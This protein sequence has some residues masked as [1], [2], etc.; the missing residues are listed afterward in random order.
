MAPGL[1]VNWQ[2]RQ[3]V[4]DK[5]I[6]IDTAGAL[7]GR[8]NNAKVCL[9]SNKTSR[10]HAHLAIDPNN[11]L[12]IVDLKSTNGTFVNGQQIP[13][14]GKQV[15]SGDIISF[16][17][18]TIDLSDELI[19]KECFF[20]ATQIEQAKNKPE[21]ADSTT[22]EL[23]N[24]I[25]PIEIDDSSDE[26]LD[27]KRHTSTP[28]DS[29]SVVKT[30]NVFK[31]EMRLNNIHTLSE[32]P[33]VI[34]SSSGRVSAKIANRVLTVSLD[35]T[36]QQPKSPKISTILTESDF[37]NISFKIDADSLDK[38]DKLLKEPAINTNGS[39]NLIIGCTKIFG[40]SRVLPDNKSTDEVE[41][42]ENVPEIKPTALL[43]SFSTNDSSN[44]LLID[45]TNDDED[46]EA[47]ISNSQICHMSQ[48]VQT[49]V[50]DDKYQ[51]IKHELAEMDYC[52]EEVI[53][54]AVPIN[55][56]DDM[57]TGFD[58]TQ[59]IWE[60]LE[61]GFEEIND[62]IDKNTHDN[63]AKDIP[64]SPE[65]DFSDNCPTNTFPSNSN[66]STVSEP[67]V[68]EDDI[69]NNC[70]STRTSK[71]DKPKNKFNKP[72][73]IEPHFIQPSTKST[74]QSLTTNS[75]STNKR[76]TSVESPV[77]IKRA[78]SVDVFNPLKTVKNVTKNMAKKRRSP[79]KP[80]VDKAAVEKAQNVLENRRAKLK[81]LTTAKGK[82]SENLSV[83]IPCS[84]MQEVNDDQTFVCP[85]TAVKTRIARNDSTK[86]STGPVEKDN[87]RCFKMPASRPQPDIRAPLSLA[88]AAYDLRRTKSSEEIK[89]GRGNSTQN[90]EKT[91][92]NSFRRS[93]GLINTQTQKLKNAL[94]TNAIQNL[95]PGTR[96]KQPKH[97]A[98]KAQ[99]S[100]SVSSNQDASRRLMW[101][102][103]GPAKRLPIRQLPKVDDIAKKMVQWLPSWLLEQVD[104]DASPPI[105]NPPATKIPQ[106]FQ[107][108]GHYYQTFY[109][110][111]L[112]E[113]WQ[114]LF[115][116]F[117][118]AKDQ[119]RKVRID[120]LRVANDVIILDCTCYITKNELKKELFYRPDDFVLL[121]CAMKTEN[122]SYASL[123]F[124]I[125]QN[126]KKTTLTEA[127]DVWIKRDLCGDP[128]TKLEFTMITRYQP[129]KEMNVKKKP[130]IKL[131]SNLRTYFMLIR[132]V[133]GF[134]NSPLHPMV[135]NPQITDYKI[136]T[137][138]HNLKYKNELN[139]EQKCTVLQ[140]AS[141]CTG[142]KP[143]IYCIK[144]PPGTG[145][146]TVIANL[147]FQIL[148]SHYYGKEQQRPMILLVA[149]SNTAIDTL[150]S[151]MMSLK[152]GVS[153]EMQTKI[154]C[155]RIG[156]ESSISKG[157]Q[158]YS[159]PRLAEKHMPLN[160]QAN[161]NIWANKQK[162][163]SPLDCLKDYFG[164]QYYHELKKGILQF[165]CCIV[166][167]ATQCHEVEVLLPT[168]L[169]IDKFVLVGD[170][171]QLSATIMN[172]DALKLGFGQSLFSRL[173]NSFGSDPRS[174]I[175]M[176]TEQY[177]MHPEI[178]SFPNSQFYEGKLRSVANPSNKLPEEI[179]PYL[180]FNLEYVNN[181]RE[182]TNMGEII[183]IKKILSSII[184]LVGKS[185]N[186]TIGI[187]TPYRAQKDLICDNIAD[188]EANNNCK[189]ITN[190]VDSF[191]GSE[192]DVIIISCVRESSNSFLQNECRLNV[193][194]T[195]AKQA[196]YIVGNYILF[197]ECRPLYNLR[198]DAKRRNVLLDI[199][200]NPN[201]I[202]NFDRYLIKK[203]NNR[204]TAV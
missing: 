90:M 87:S 43:K 58:N 27:D 124:G 135:L 116:G 14:S 86:Y 103:G 46:D 101:T 131:L 160:H 59:D 165:T 174:P 65:I 29:S 150:L 72:P 204:N 119:P 106:T 195:R 147:V 81:E 190:T 92:P 140:A 132:A 125:I 28:S 25:I 55:L 93:T 18:S 128:H 192:N 17:L 167:E 164:D 38:K 188:L 53:V 176:L 49:T 126:C 48:I 109:K 67:T 133:K 71:S 94:K 163:Q 153:V 5:L 64:V 193:A 138:H 56:E 26:F 115:S 202:T 168:L 42:V 120:H 189:I 137:T 148:F 3:I 1:S 6:L 146:S 198:E 97:A 171:Q 151:K 201:T 203:R 37:G 31:S 123:N 77:K 102:N 32:A 52:T 175:K 69:K 7:V 20:Q 107:D 172:R 108:F 51:Q 145:K 41:S 170:P 62:K 98:A 76:K 23:D 200:Q 104:I 121:E 2:L 196:L 83:D 35:R 185:C 127:C 89:L 95:P 39:G 162:H 194:L 182:Y 191:Q 199:K 181:S 75:K 177:R 22:N 12:N 129:D 187:I 156:P 111:I 186:Y 40:N 70:N 184:S 78:K 173:A 9:R 118:E 10:A 15:C 44:C 158:G 178:C 180:V 47:D 34:S 113:S 16:G 30:E 73:I 144:G 63:N 100:A 99:Y 169:G 13:V 105:N 8:S 143:G 117:R 136:T 24:S 45:L 74:K 60:L 91:N 33:M 142:N 154:K 122:N 80:T 134:A 166:D 4:S 11:N 54:N 57:E 149:P 85:S 68:P 157:V 110:L 61:G 84:S 159:L 96:M 88:R 36:P 183:V 66:S 139:V 50:P 19:D 112:L 161:A 155:V 82:C 114:Y 130:I 141:L 152:R 79:L 21:A 197:K 179:K